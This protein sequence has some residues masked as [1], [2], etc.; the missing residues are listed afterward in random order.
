MLLSV[1]HN[2]VTLKLEHATEKE[3]EYFCSQ[4]TTKQ[5]VFSKK[6]M[7]ELTYIRLYQ[8]TLSGFWKRM[9]DIQKITGIPVKIEGLIDEPGKLGIVDPT[10]KKDILDEWIDSH[11][12]LYTP[13]WYQFEAVYNALK[14]RFSRCEVATAGGKSYMIFLYCRYL[15]EHNKMPKDSKI[16]VVTIRKM[17]VT[18]LVDDFKKYE[19]EESEEDHLLKCD[20]VF[21]G[22]RK[23]DESNVV[24]GTYQSL[25][26]YDKEYFSQFGAIVIDECHQAHITSIKDEI[27]PKLD[28]TRCHY[29]WGLSGTQPLPKTF[30][31]LHLEA[32]VGPILFRIGAADLQEEG[33]IAKIQIKMV[34]FHYPISETSTFYH[35]PDAS[36]DRIT[37]SLSCEKKWVQ[38]HEKRCN[39]IKNI[40]ARFEGNQVVMVESVEYAKY[41]RDLFATIEGKESYLIY[42]EVKD[43]VRNEIKKSFET[44]TNKVLVATSETMSTGVSI[45]NIMAVHF[46]DGGKSRVRIRQS[47]GRGLRLH[48][49]KEYLTVF[50]YNDHLKKPTAKFCE[51]N[52][53]E[54]WPGPP[55]N[56]LYNQGRARKKI[57]DE[58]KFPVQIIDFDM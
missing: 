1:Q 25:S 27:I 12:F 13:R 14:F 52:G 4:A 35:N 33:A 58:E 45:N 29:R 34:T 49:A 32:Y 44:G 43:S 47:C 7:I 30:E 9:L 39:I 26:N 54:E 11:S 38:F 18:Q 10:I 5:Y 40:V 36:S 46:P 42:G 19:S 31:D 8:Y 56:R 2:G 37:K 6:K 28:H 50:D 57:Y 55:I 24:I 22:G 48:A 17:L 41:L 16:L 51:K 15:L 3:L 20:T 23:F 53:I 21:S